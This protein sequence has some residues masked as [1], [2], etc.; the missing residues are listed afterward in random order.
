LT[1]ALSGGVDFVLRHDEDKLRQTGE[2]G[3]VNGEMVRQG[4]ERFQFAQMV[5]TGIAGAGFLMS[6]VGIWGDGF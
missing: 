2:E 6:I 3:S 5:R 1:V 4:M